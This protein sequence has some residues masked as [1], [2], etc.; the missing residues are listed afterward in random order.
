M[1][2]EETDQRGKDDKVHMELFQSG[3]L[4]ELVEVW[5]RNLTADVISSDRLEARI[6]LDPNFREKFCLIARRGGNMIGFV[7][8]ICGEGFQFPGK[9]A[10]DRAWILAIAVESEYRLSGVGTEL[11]NILEKRFRKAGK[12][13]IWIASYPTAYIVPGVDVDAYSDGIAFFQARGYRTAHTAFSMDAIIWPPKFPEEVGQ[14]KLARQGISLHTYDSQWLS[15]F[16]RF[17]RSHVPWDWEWLAL[18]NLSRISEGT[19]SP[20]QFLLAI[21]EDEVVGYCQYEAEHFGPFGVAQGFQGKGIG[22]AL[23]ARALYSMAQHGIHNAWVLWTGEEAARLYSRFG[24]SKSR[25]FAILHK[26]I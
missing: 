14:E 5:N 11:L 4:E 9:L 18:R 13:K 15:A 1:P 25:E 6:L 17:L 23:L 26:E 21:S 12:R 22:T 2:I 20:E 24:F 3:D 8:G 19:F 7:L 10:G 16:R